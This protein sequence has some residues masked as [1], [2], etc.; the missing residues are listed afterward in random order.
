MKR[1]LVKT[2]AYKTLATAELSL[3]AWLIT[4]NLHAAG[5]VGMAHLALSTFT[6][7]GFDRVFEAIWK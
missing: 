2:I 5:H 7:A 4:G 3:I 6:Y 1:M